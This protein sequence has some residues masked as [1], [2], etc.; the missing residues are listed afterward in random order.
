MVTSV[1]FSSTS[2]ASALAARSRSYGSWTNAFATQLNRLAA[3]DN[4]PAEARAAALARDPSL[5]AA[6]AKQEEIEAR[7]TAAK[8]EL[9]GLPDSPFIEDADGNPAVAEGE[10][11][12]RFP[13]GVTWADARAMVTRNKVVGDQIVPDKL[14]SAVADQSILGISNQYRLTL[15]DGTTGEAAAAQLAAQLA[16][17]AEAKDSL[18]EAGLGEQVLAAITALGLTPDPDNVDG[19]TPDGLPERFPEGL[20]YVYLR[21]KI[22]VPQIDGVE[23][24]AETLERTLVASEKLAEARITPLYPTWPPGTTVL[25]AFEDSLKQNKNNILT[26]IFAANDLS[27][28]DFP[29]KIGR[30]QAYKMVEDPAV[31]GGVDAEKVTALKTDFTELKSLGIYDIGRFKSLGGTTPTKVLKIITDRPEKFRPTRT[32][33]EASRPNW[34]IPD[35]LVL[36]GPVSGAAWEAATVEHAMKFNPDYTEEE[37]MA[38]YGF[39]TVRVLG[40]GERL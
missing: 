9:L 1:D 35:T 34:K 12:R 33:I 21:Q 20:S 3:L 10:T 13:A 4:L 19:F 38:R 2:A 16:A 8:A 26:A 18:L 36:N 14:R 29:S 40:Q 7:N 15:V 25:Q 23:L 24:D 22:A 6:A 17:E 32:E 31:P 11:L 5:A 28:R 30:Y 37:I 39:N 27:L